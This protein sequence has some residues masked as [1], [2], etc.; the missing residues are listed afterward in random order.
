MC[1]SF[2]S[3]CDVSRVMFSAQLQLFLILEY[4]CWKSWNWF[5]NEFTVRYDCIVYVLNYS[6][7]LI[8]FYG[9]WLL[10]AKGAMCKLFGSSC[11]MS[12]VMFIAQ[13]QLFLILEY[14]CWKSWNWLWKDECTVCYNCIVHFLMLLITPGIKSGLMGDDCLTRR[15]H[16]SEF[17]MSLCKLTI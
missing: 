15:N 5:W 12:T 4:L 1:K 14:L 9:R 2:G 11:D 8:R 16:H 3:T 10:R 6:R 17:S 7:N 13:L